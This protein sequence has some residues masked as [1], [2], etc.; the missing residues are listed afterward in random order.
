MRTVITQ[1]PSGT[2]A[3]LFRCH[4]EEYKI[5][6]ILEI[7]NDDRVRKLQHAGG[8]R[9]TTYALYIQYVGDDDAS[10]VS[11]MT[12]AFSL[13][14]TLGLLQSQT[15]STS[16]YSP[17]VI[18]SFIL[19]ISRHV[20]KTPRRPTNAAMATVPPISD[21]SKTEIP[22]PVEAAEVA[23][24]PAAEVADPATDVAE[25]PTPDVRLEAM[26]P[27][28]ELP[29]LVALEDEEPV[30]ELPEVEADDDGDVLELPP[31]EDDDED[32]D[33]LELPELVELALP[34]VIEDKTLDP[35]LPAELA[36]REVS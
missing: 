22:S 5:S 32:G 27:I 36:I 17:Y 16:H 33:V 6:C 31:E 12:S 29:L 19:Y 25:E 13:F 34:P 9:F 24:D 14:C 15:F 23:A 35:K 3:L 7:L 28:P 18:I 1:Q 10:A 8:K 2:A 26:P 20:Y 30:P 11:F 4:V 21:A